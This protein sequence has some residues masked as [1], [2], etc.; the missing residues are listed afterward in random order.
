VI[1]VLTLRIYGT[2]ANQAPQI[3][4]EFFWAAVLKGKHKAQVH[5]DQMILMVVR[6][7]AGPEGL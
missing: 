1:I 5:S 2:F 7:E 6:H 4:L 3:L